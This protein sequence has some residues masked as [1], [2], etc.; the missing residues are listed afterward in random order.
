MTDQSPDPSN[1]LP[2]S[3][4]REALARFGANAHVMVSDGDRNIAPGN[5]SRVVHAILE[6]H[7]ALTA[8]LAKRQ[9]I[10]DACLYEM[11]VGYLPAHTAE[12]LP[13]HIGEM[14]RRYAETDALEDKL[15]LATRQRE[16]MRSSVELCLEALSFIKADRPTV[17]S[18]EVWL[19]FNHA[20]ESAAAALANNKATT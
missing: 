20:I 14:C 10:I 4:L 2:F 5:F 18:D 8:G 12:K 16:E 11:P 6:S 17:H 1:P 15:A 9:A 19:A 13:A 3:G 7:D